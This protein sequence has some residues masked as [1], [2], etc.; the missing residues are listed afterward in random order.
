MTAKAQAASKATSAD[1]LAAIMA[2]LEPWCH[3]DAY[4]QPYYGLVT[5]RFPAGPYSFD[6]MV[7]PEMAKAGPG[8]TGR[9]IRAHLIERAEN[10]LEALA[11][12]GWHLTAYPRM[13][14]NGEVRRFAQYLDG[15]LAEPSVQGAISL[16]MR[17]EVDRPR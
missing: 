16:R 10:A 8:V 15:T 17:F 7:M 14:I 11:S 3:V 2:I 1:E 5:G 13:E 9:E 12:A 4:G 6:T